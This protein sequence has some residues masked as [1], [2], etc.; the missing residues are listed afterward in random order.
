ML[1]PNFLIVGAM[2]SGTTSLYRYLRHHP[3]VTMTTIKEPRFFSFMGESQN[4]FQAVLQ[5]RNW[6]FKTI[7]HTAD[8][9]ALFPQDNN[10]MGDA[11]PQYLYLHEKTIPNIQAFYGRDYNKLKIIIILRNPVERAYSDYMMWLSNGMVQE[12]FEYFLFD[13]VTNYDVTKLP[14]KPFMNWVD[15]GFYY[16]QV[17]HYMRYFPH[18]KVFLFDEL[19][20]NTPQLLMQLFE[21]IEVD[22][23]AFIPNIT[24]QYNIS[25]KPRNRYIHALFYY[26]NILRTCL[27]TVLPA[28]VYYNLVERIRQ[29]N[30][31][32]ITMKQNTRHYLQGIY[33]DDLV[34]LQDLI[35][36]DLS[37][38]L[39]EKI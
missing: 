21:F 22:P 24:R 13:H 20:E 16:Q 26:E 4:A 8:Y 32:P 7:N 1:K 39:R 14:L 31:K 38:W 28:H 10:A 17:A 12:P 29:L 34:K 9:L 3:Q 19:K 2:K 35:Q 5:K 30:L 15:I 25:G 11:S 37:D 33:H 36:R 27:E 18:T 6:T 23:H